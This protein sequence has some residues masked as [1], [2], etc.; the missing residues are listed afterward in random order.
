M[1]AD[2]TN[3]TRVT[4]DPQADG[5]PVFT[6]DGS[7]LVFQSL[8]SGK[9]QIWTAA[10]D[11]SGARALTTDSVNQTPAVSPDG[12]TIAY[13]SVRNKNYDIWLMSRDGSNQR[14]FTK[15][16]QQNET[17]PRFL[18][19]GSLAFIVE[20]REANRT[21]R[22]VVKADLATGAITPLTGTDLPIAGFAVSSRGDLIALVVP[23]DPNNR[24]N[25]L[26]RVQLLTVGAGTPTPIP[27]GPTEQMMAPTFLP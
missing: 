18:G 26:Y 13:A 8:R 21:V 6:A 25:P 24:R 9:P 16:P 5:R 19:D 2:G 12:G 7:G 20:R 23:T 11:G 14:A 17:E 27:A 4:S 15:A 22:M 1:D 3:L 10:L